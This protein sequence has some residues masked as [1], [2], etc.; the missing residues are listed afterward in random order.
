MGSTGSSVEMGDSGVQLSS[1]GSVD[2]SS[3]SM[4]TVASVDVSA[5][6]TDFAVASE[7]T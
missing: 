2:L 6:A 3:G 1:T 4:I 7:T 5:S